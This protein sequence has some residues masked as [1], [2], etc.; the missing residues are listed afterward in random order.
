MEGEDEE[1]EGWKEDGICFK[2]EFGSNERN[3]SDDSNGKE[4]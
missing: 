1:E 3:K 4:W 2:E